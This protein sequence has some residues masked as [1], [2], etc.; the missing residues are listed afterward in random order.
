MGSPPESIFISQQDVIELT[1]HPRPATQVR[2]L[3]TNEIPFILG[4]DGAPKVL[5]QTLVDKL[6]P[7][8]LP[9]AGVITPRCQPIEATETWDKVM[10]PLMAELIGTTRKALEHQRLSGIIPPDVWAKVNG[11]VMYSLKRYDA[12]LESYWTEITPPRRKSKP[13]RGRGPT[14]NLVHLLT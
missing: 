11:R 2:W 8:A 7:Q 14:D 10:E 3:R 4:G 12:W 9:D 5:R 13:Q 1:G 6:K